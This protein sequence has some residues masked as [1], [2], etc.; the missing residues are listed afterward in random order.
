MNRTTTMLRTSN[1]LMTTMTTSDYPNLNPCYLV[2]FFSPLFSPAPS[3]ASI[4]ALFLVWQI[5]STLLSTTQ[6]GF[7]PASYHFLLFRFLYLMLCTCVSFLG[8]P[9][10]AL[11]SLRGGHLRGRAA[12]DVPVSH[13]VTV[14]PLAQAKTFNLI[15]YLF[16]ST[17]YLSH[18]IVGYALLGLLPCRDR[19]VLV[20]CNGV[21]L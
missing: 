6:I 12:E 20:R 11:P 10:C 13:H 17:R 19:G 16:P 1:E 8:F 9:R 15:I 2:P 7:E 14:C 21:F 3:D 4:A 18:V 5:F